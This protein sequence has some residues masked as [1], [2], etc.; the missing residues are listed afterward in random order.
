MD[1]TKTVFDLIGR[2]EE[3]H[4]TGIGLSVYMITDF[5]NL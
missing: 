4:N 2:V 1:L 5:T 3:M